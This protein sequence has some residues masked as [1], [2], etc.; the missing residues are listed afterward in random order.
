M[1]LAVGG[2]NEPDITLAVA[3]ME[4]IPVLR[5]LPTEEA[6]QHLC[7]DKG[8]D[9]HWLRWSIVLWGLTPHFRMRGEEVL[10]KSEHPAVV[11]FWSVVT[12]D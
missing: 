8:Y 4:R 10:E 5:P 9:A 6:P 7:L 3:T 1:G 2:A 12:V 11:G